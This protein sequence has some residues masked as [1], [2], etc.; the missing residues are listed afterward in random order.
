MLTDDYRLFQQVQTLVP[1]IHWYTLCSPDEQGYVNSSFTQTAKELK[2][3]QMTR[4]LSSIQILMNASVFIGSITA[5]PSLFLLK[6]FYPS[7]SPADCSLKDFPYAST[8]P[9][10]GRGQ[11]ATEYIRRH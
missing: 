7:I 4:F 9:I 2:Q 3:K 5:G 6:K 11:V 8:L 10:P 1:E